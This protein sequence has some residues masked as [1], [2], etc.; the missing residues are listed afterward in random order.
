MHPAPL[1]VLALLL[2]LA[3]FPLASAHTE[4]EDD[5]E[6]FEDVHEAL[7]QQGKA[8]DEVTGMRETDSERH[9]TCRVDGRAV[10]YVLKKE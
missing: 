8:C 9:V 4:E 6:L 7:I 2:L 5:A 3:A 10:E 1:R